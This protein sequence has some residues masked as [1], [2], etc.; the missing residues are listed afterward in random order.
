LL[1]GWLVLKEHLTVR[2]AIGAASVISSVVTLQFSKAHIETR[3][4]KEC[5]VNGRAQKTK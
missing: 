5:A 1:L 4:K 3:Q 2:T